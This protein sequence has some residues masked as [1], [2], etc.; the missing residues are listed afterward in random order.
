M[1]QEQTVAAMDVSI[2]HLPKT[3]KS[4]VSV[5]GNKHSSLEDSMG[6]KVALGVG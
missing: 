4:V 3:E 6:D 1:Q 2:G 5:S